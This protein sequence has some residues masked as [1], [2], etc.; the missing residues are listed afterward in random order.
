MFLTGNREKLA[1]LQRDLEQRVRQDLDE[2]M[3][4][5]GGP[6]QVGKTTLEQLFQLGGFPE[7]FLWLDMFER[8][9]AVFSS[10][11][12]APVP[13]TTRVQDLRTRSR[14]SH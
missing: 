10:G 13:P 12:S 2:N 5:R 9:Y 1:C 8:L 4:F 14:S 3:V 7:P 6:R 11:C